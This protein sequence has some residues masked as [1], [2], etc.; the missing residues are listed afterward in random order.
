MS[1]YHFWNKTA[2]L[3]SRHEDASNKP[4]DV[5]RVDAYLGKNK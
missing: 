5:V 4:T 2:H 3:R 1:E